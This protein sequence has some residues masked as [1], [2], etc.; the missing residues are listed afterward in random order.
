MKVS[1]KITNIFNNL[2]DYE[3]KQML[4]LMMDEKP[5]E[6]GLLSL[7]KVGLI[8]KPVT[9]TNEQPKKCIFHSTLYNKN[10]I[11]KCEGNFCTQTGEQINSI[12]S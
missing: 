10:I 5:E 4:Q 9:T 7:Q 12:F 1:N 11:C 3:L 2:K 6:S 8:N